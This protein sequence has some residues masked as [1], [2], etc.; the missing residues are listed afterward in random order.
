MVHVINA[1][2]NIHTTRKPR[3]LA[4]A[5][6][7]IVMQTTHT[8]TDMKFISKD[9]PVMIGF[10]KTRILLRKERSCLTGISG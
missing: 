3:K 9:G 8:N 10:V 7:L 6:Y 2:F 1:F 4:S 5:P